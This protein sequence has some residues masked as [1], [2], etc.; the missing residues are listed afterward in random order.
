MAVSALAPRGFA[1]TAFGDILQNVVLLA[2]TIALLVNVRTA[3]AR[4]RLFW[5]LMGM[6][7]AMW[8]GSQ[9]MW[10]YVE[11]YLCHEAPNPF[12]GDVILFLHIVP[13]MAAVALQPH[14]QQENRAIRA[15]RLD[16]ALLF[17][18]WLFLYL[19]VVI[20]WSTYSLRKL[21]MAEVLISFMCPKS[22]FWREVCS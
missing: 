3:P 19:F 5:A 1:L 17:T 9:L 10:T 11:V 21:S 15:G 6:G 7:L 20:P 13:M 22:W 14:V 18:W 8:L 12:A 4:S 16:F 2:A